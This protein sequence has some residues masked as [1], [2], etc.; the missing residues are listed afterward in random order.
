MKFLRSPIVWVIAT[1]VAFVPATFEPVNSLRQK[2]RIEVKSD[3][4]SVSLGNRPELCEALMDEASVVTFDFD[5]AARRLGGYQNFF[6]TDRGNL[7][8]R[9]EVAEDGRMA[10]VF[11]P[12]APGEE[13]AGVTAN[14]KIRS[15][16][17]TRV[18][19][20]VSRSSEVS[21]YFNKRPSKTYSGKFL[22]ECADVQVGSGFDSTRVFNGTVRAVIVIQREEIVTYFGLPYVIRQ[23]GQLLF[24]S[25]GLVTLVILAYEKGRRSMK[26]ERNS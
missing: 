25:L 3:G 23:L 16:E 17:P 24:V 26:E 14:G 2:Q 21:L 15:G 6:Q 11:R 13:L 5:V 20:V 1:A 8:L 22:V 12:D 4:K 19:V 10:V 18:R 7:G 9:I